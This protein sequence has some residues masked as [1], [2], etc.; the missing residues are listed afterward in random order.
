MT[1]LFVTF[2][3]TSKILLLPSVQSI[4]DKGYD[5]N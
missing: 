1:K 4:L 5:L 2:E 3:N